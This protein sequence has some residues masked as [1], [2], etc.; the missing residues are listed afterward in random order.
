MK[1]P[2]TIEQAI[3]Q[4]LRA[5]R[6]KADKTQ[7]AVAAALGV[8]HQAYQKY[9]D[10]DVRITIGA[11]VRACAA[12]QAEPA[13]ILP[14]LMPDR[15]PAPDPFAA[16]AATIGGYELADHY[17]RMGPDQRRSLL[18]VAKTIATACAV[19]SAIAGAA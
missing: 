12:L 18:S 15:D 5:A 6:L 14:R 7:A 8:S 1:S 13:E 4:R 9:E 16:Q 10:G 19:K 11:F 3:G 2:L 17:A